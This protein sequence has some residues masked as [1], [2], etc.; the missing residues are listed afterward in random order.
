MECSKTVVD[1]SYAYS[2]GLLH[3]RTIF[4]HSVYLVSRVGDSLCLDFQLRFTDDGGGNWLD[5]T[6]L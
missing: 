6:Y 2:I 5:D 4:N 1:V 3:L